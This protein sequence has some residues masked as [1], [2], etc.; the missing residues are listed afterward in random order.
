[1]LSSCFCLW[2]NKSGLNNS[3][4]RSKYWANAVVTNTFIYWFGNTN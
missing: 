3:R 4:N 2:G 1:M